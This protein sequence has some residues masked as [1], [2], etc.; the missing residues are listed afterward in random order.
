MTYGSTI[1]HT[2]RK[3]WHFRITQGFQFVLV[4]KLKCSQ[5]Q[6]KKEKEKKCFIICVRESKYQILQEN[7]LHLIIQCR[8]K[9]QSQI[10]I[11]SMKLIFFSDFMR[12]FRLWCFQKHGWHWVRRV[13]G[14]S[15]AGHQ[16]KVVWVP[17]VATPW[18]S[19][20]GYWQS[21]TGQ[22]QCWVILILILI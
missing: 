11:S 19:A 2:W 4:L 21:V 9:N 12:T 18:A 20:K 6:K 8:L 14:W 13:P 7:M 5:K 16:D 3:I 17:C 1:S 10:Q 15:P 22:D